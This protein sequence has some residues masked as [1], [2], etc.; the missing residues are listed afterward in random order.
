M[1]GQACPHLWRRNEVACED[2]YSRGRDRSGSSW[3]VREKL[4]AEAWRI[5]QGSVSSVCVTWSQQNVG[6][7][8]MLVGFHWKVKVQVLEAWKQPWGR[9]SWVKNAELFSHIRAE[10]QQR[11][12]RQGVGLRRKGHYDLL[13]TH[14]KEWPG[15]KASHPSPWHS[16][17]PLQGR[18]EMQK[19]KGHPHNLSWTGSSAGL[20]S[21][22][23]SL[24]CVYWWSERGSQ[25][26]QWKT[27]TL[28]TPRAHLLHLPFLSPKE[29]YAS[30]SLLI[31]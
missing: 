10:M 7:R 30:R 27:R 18:R 26:L 6:S 4:T 25:L 31:S 20:G 22:S 11:K 17:S 23:L 2:W 3:R 21:P 8:E 28:C 29:A 9:D 12:W 5:R 14:G 13:P 16:L 19:D 24:S 15:V 1:L